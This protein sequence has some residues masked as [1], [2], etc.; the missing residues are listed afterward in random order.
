MGDSRGWQEET[1]GPT[2]RRDYLSARGPTILMGAD[3]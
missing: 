1:K 3:P 2:G